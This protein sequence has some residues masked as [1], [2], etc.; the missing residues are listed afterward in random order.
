VLAIVNF[1]LIQKHILHSIHLNLKIS[2]LH[3]ED[4][5]KYS[6]KQST[7]KLRVDTK[8]TSISTWFCVPRQSRDKEI[9]IHLYFSNRI[10]LTRVEY[11]QLCVFFT[12]KFVKFDKTFY[13]NLVFFDFSQDLHKIV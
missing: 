13:T 4:R 6:D 11:N 2:P 12:Q 3:R 10:T 5:L 1:F 7:V 8:T 9:Q